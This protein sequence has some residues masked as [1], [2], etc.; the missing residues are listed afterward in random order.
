[1]IKFMS[2]CNL[3]FCFEF[4]SFLF[5]LHVTGCVIQ[6]L[7]SYLASRM[8]GILEPKTTPFFL[9]PD[10]KKKLSGCHYSVLEIC[11]LDKIN[12]SN[13][14]QSIQERMS[15]LR[16]FDPVFPFRYIDCVSGSR[17]KKQPL[18]RVPVRATRNAKMV[19]A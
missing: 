19:E 17:D 10:E 8:I 14:Y 6:L 7:A 3:F 1:M 11:W 5:I 9:Q 12:F 16:E 13:L 15:C 4:A 18:T 2:A